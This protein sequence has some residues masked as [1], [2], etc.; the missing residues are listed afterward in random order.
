MSILDLFKGNEGHIIGV[1]LTPGVG[2]E[3]AVLD[4]SKKQVA[5]YARRNVQYNFQTREIQDLG[6]FK[7]KFADLMDELQIP[8]KAEI[9]LVLPNVLFDFLEAP[10]ELSD[11]DVK[12]M[13]LTKAEEF[14]LFKRDEPIS[15]WCEVVNFNGGTQKKYAYTSFQKSIIDQIRDTIAELGFNVI[16]IESSYSATLRGLFLTGLIDDTIIDNSPWSMLLLN[17]NSYTLFQMEGRNI[18]TYTDVPLAIKSF[19]VEEAYQAILQGA[20]QLISNIIA[21]KLFIVSQTDDVSAEVLKHQMQFDKEIIAI[22]SNKFAKKPPMEV[23]SANDTK[24]ANSLTLSSIGAASGTVDF[25]FVLNVLKDDPSIKSDIY[26]I[27][28]NGKIQ[29]VTG[30]QIDA[31]CILASILV[32]II[33][34][35]LVAIVY[36]YNSMNT[37]KLNDINSQITTIDAQI[38]ELSKVEQKNEVDIN[39]IIDEIAEQ[40]VS[41]ISFY[42][43]IS[44]D[45]P[46]NV[47][48]TKYYNKNGKDIAVR[49]I[50]ESIIDIYEY[51]KNLRIVSPQSDIK[52]NELKVITSDN[53]TEDENKFLSGLTLVQDKDRLY[54]FE[55]SNTQIQYPSEDPKD[56]VNENDLLRQPPKVE[57]EETSSQMTEAK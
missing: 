42:D 37:N 36:F 52:L 21:S 29:E 11:E 32:G 18:V 35:A 41:T 5:K 20:S 33:G 46:K 17:T 57:V 25:S 50:A 24:K 40:N 19:S 16:G 44:T 51:Y 45:I 47:W 49:G 10:A 13:V 43:S 4:K 7:S 56:A 23:I 1:S 54:S 9:N 30:A 22:D 39:S 38:A 8:P 6:Q 27:N 31:L 15:G 26:K 28:L 34:F 55:I 12:T 3:A 48:L 53:Q 14:Y 2:L